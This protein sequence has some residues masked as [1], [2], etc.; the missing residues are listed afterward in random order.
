[1]LIFISAKGFQNELFSLNYYSNYFYKK[2][3]LKNNSDNLS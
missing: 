1:M 3:L 2:T